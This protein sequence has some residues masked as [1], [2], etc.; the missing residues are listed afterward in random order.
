ME[1]NVDFRTTVMWR[2]LPA[3]VWNAIPNIQE[4]TWLTEL[5]KAMT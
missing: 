1:V 3:T 5:P 2:K 4:T